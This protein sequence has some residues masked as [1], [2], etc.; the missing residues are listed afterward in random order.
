M[1]PETADVVVVGGGPAGLFCAAHLPAALD[2][3]LLERMPEPGRKLL[4]S[5]SGQANLTHTGDLAAFLDRYGDDDHGRFLRHALRSLSNEGLGRWFAD[6][7]VPLETRE[8]GKVFPASR[9]AQDVLEALQTACTGNGVRLLPGARVGSIERTPGGFRIRAD[10]VEVDARAVVLAT[11]GASY[12]QTGSSGD[13]YRLAA[14][15][16]HTVVEPHPALAPVEPDPYPFADL[17]GVSVPDA[18]FVLLR[19]DRRLRARR[20]DLL[21]THRG[22]SGPGVLDLSRDVRPG[23]RLLLSFLPDLRPEELDARMIELCRDRGAARLPAALAPLHLPE[24]LLRRL[25]HQAGL[26]EETTGARMTKEQRRAVTTALTAFPL[27]VGRV[28]DFAVAMATAGG[29]AL[30][31]VDPKTMGSRLVP[32]LFFA[33]EVLDLDGDSGGYNLQA[34]FSTGAL[35]ATGVARLLD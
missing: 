11:G 26:P 5:G 17:A 25:L 15:L 30:G 2:V 1:T 20:G 19:G 3:L 28:G 21:F 24:R 33:G 35:A 12:A 10:Q 6:R 23:D 32:G 16:G 4:L 13:G 8:D 31:E 7:E 34:A 29:V 22:L 27:A 18:G 14:A 9:R